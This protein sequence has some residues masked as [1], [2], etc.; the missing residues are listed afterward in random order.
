MTGLA[1]DV[2]HLTRRLQQRVEHDTII[3]DSAHWSPV[4]EKVHALAK[5]L[6]EATKYKG[7]RPFGVQAL[8]IGR[9]QQQHEAPMSLFSLD[10]SGGYRHWGVATA[11]GKAA[12][13]VRRR[14]YENLVAMPD[15]TT[16]ETVLR[17]SLNATMSA[18]EESADMDLDMSGYECLIVWY[19]RGRIRVAAVDPSELTRMQKSL[20]NAEEA[21]STPS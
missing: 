3:Y 4:L 11:I 14:L 16:V 18:L 9:Q 1:S 12:S 7:D 6:R 19:E 15:L 17:V 8:L 5:M 21:A 13:L 10:P 20:R 2:D